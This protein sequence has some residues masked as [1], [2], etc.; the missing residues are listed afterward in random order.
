MTA[1]VQV[2]IDEALNNKAAAVL[3]SMGLSVADVVRATLDRIASDKAL[4]FEMHVPNALTARTLA[5]SERGE[6]VYE[7][8]DA[9]DL[10]RQLGI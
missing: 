7:A 10:F 3:A 9:A 4:P 5:A 2:H 8:R 1:T 6:D